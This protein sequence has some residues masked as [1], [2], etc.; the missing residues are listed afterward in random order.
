MVITLLVLS[1][2]SLYSVEKFYK[3]NWLLQNEQAANIRRKIDYFLLDSFTNNT[4]GYR[5]YVLENAPGLY[6]WRPLR[7]MPDLDLP[8]SWDG[9]TEFNTIYAEVKDWKPEENILSVYTFISQPG[10]LHLDLSDGGEDTK[11]IVPLVDEFGRPLSSS[12]VDENSVTEGMLTNFLA[13]FDNED[14]LVDYVSQFSS[15]EDLTSFMAFGFGGLARD[16]LIKDVSGHYDWNDAFCETDML[17]VSF[18]KDVD[19][20]SIETE[21]T[22]TPSMVIMNQ[23]GCPVEYV[24]SDVAPEIDYS[25][26]PAKIHEPTDAESWIFEYRL[27]REDISYL[28]NSE[29]VTQ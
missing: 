27:F 22:V 2:V 28:E 12:T 18:T 3:S 29:G 7:I 5:D 20:S 21:A 16:I 17:M 8:E 14:D 6:T 24:Q 26:L 15:V 23:G 13:L 11:L 25:Q 1:V 19:I 9:E 4:L 10:F